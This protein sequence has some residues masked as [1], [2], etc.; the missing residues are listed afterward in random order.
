VQ[1]G[2]RRWSRRAGIATGIGLGLMLLAHAAPMTAFL[3]PT[4]FAIFVLP[5]ADAVAIPWF[6]FAGGLVLL[7]ALYES[8][9]EWVRIEPAAEMGSP[10]DRFATGSA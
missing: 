8:Y 10:A 4:P 1:G 3:D 7:G 5:R 6:R 2:W 9:L